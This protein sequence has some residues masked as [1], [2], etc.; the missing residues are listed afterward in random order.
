MAIYPYLN[1]NE[2]TKEAIC[3]YKD[4]FEAE[5][6]KIMYFGEVPPDENFPYT[7]DTKDLVMHASLDINGSI[8]MFSDATSDNKVQFNGNITLF[9]ETKDRDLLYRIYNKLKEGGKTDM[10]L[11]ETFWSKAYGFVIDKYGI[12]WQLNLDE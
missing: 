2:N 3:F 5:E 1:F 11:Q 8:L 12:G 7:D 6:P 4:V 9:Y 10:E